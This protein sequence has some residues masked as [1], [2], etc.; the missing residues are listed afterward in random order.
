[1]RRCYMWLILIELATYW[2][3]WLVVNGS[4]INV[5]TVSDRCICTFRS[6]CL[7][8][9]HLSYF[10]NYCIWQEKTLCCIL[11]NK[12]GHPAVWPTFDHFF[13]SCCRE[14]DGWRHTEREIWKSAYE[15]FLGLQVCWWIIKRSGIKG[16]EKSMSYSGVKKTKYSEE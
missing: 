4:F 1:M 5:V 15:Y 7:I 14:T 16:H 12:T 8:K 3:C 10:N 2:M 6:L 9:Q 13:N 11:I